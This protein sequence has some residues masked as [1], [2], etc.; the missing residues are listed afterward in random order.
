MKP[1]NTLFKK[2]MKMK[3]EF[4]IEVNNEIIDKI[5]KLNEDS[6]NWRKMYM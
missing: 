2:D 4:P 3:I 6:G 5:I 1:E